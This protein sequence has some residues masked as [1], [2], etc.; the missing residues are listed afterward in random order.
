M[1]EMDTGKKSFNA[2][3]ADQPYLARFLQKLTIHYMPGSF[4]SDNN[5]DL[6]YV[7]QF[8]DRVFPLCM[9]YPH[10]SLKTN[11]HLRYFARQ[12]LGLFL[13]AFIFIFNFFFFSLLD[14][15]LMKVNNTFMMNSLRK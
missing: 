13:K 8:A 11:H 2:K 6:N 12:Q 5:Y 14:L 15:L 3:L 10:K 4:I 9:L 1:Q 7:K